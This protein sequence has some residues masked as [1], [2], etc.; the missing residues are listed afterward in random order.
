MWDNLNLHQKNELMKLYIQNGITSLD[1]MKNHYNSFA[2][3]G[4]LTFQQ[5]KAQM[6]SKY[7]D[8]EMDNNKAGYDYETY[9]NDNYN[10]A[11]A[12]LSNLRHFPDTYKLYNHPTFSNESIYSR[13]PM[14]G[15]SWGY[16][17][18]WETQWGGTEAFR[19]SIVNKQV[20]PNIYKEDR[21]YTEEEIY[22]RQNR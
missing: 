12:Q 2:D 4:K 1:E 17:H 6:Q 7:P 16:A 19:P 20:Y 13:G 18:P 22:G 10:E 3:G 5:W 11:I 9:F 14:I 15:G 21:P 8:I